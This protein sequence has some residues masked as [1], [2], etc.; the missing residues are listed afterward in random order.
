[1]FENGH[2]YITQ[3]LN[4]EKNGEGK[5]YE[6]EGDIKFNSNF[7]NDKLKGNKIVLQE[8]FTKEEL[9]IARRNGFILI[10]RI[11]AGNSTLINIL[12]NKEVAEVKKSTS[13]VTKESKIYYLKLKNGRYISFFNRHSWNI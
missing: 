3:C 10:G 6:K 12:F 5:I 4:D 11:G 8:N 1:M 9:E 7:T 13:V 2:Y